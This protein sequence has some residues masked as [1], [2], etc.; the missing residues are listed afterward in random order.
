[1]IAPPVDEINELK[2]KLTAA[3]RT[4][5]TPALAE[6]Q[7]QAQA[8]ANSQSRPGRYASDPLRARAGALAVRCATPIRVLLTLRVR[9]CCSRRCASAA[10]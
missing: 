2:P 8:Q 4:V 6:P 9:C 1:M 5:Q 3:L 7:P 10:L